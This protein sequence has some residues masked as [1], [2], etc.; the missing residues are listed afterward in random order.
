M[1]IKDLFSSYSDSQD[2]HVALSTHQEC[3]CRHQAWVCTW[4][5][6]SCRI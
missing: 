5:V 1:D 4:A 2:L 3:I 6:V